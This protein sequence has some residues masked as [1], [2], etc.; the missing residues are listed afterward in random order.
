[1]V[2][3]AGEDPSQLAELLSGVR[4]RPGCGAVLDTSFN[5]HGQPLVCTPASALDV[6]AKSG[7]EWVAIV[8]F[9]SRGLAR[10]AEALEASSLRRT[11]TTPPPLAPGAQRPLTTCVIV[12]RPAIP[13]KSVCRR[14]LTV[15]VRS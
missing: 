15:T 5:V 2:I 3:G 6:L 13:N 7:A 9:S 8:R 1:V 12:R 4:A 10:P 11:L 14:S